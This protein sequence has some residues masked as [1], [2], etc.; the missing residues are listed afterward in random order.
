MAPPR[1]T[2]LPI[3]CTCGRLLAETKLAPGSVVRIKC[4]CGET[5]V[6]QIA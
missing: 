4:R 1:S 2:L 3:R 5:T 6:L